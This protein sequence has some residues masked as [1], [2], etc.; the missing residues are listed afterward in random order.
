MKS[1]GRRRSRRR[2]YGG[3]DREVAKFYDIKD[4]RRS[5]TRPE[6]AAE[7]EARLK[8]EEEREKEMARQHI[9]RSRWHAGVRAGAA[10]SAP[11]IVRVEKEVTFLISVLTVT[12]QL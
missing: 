10:A 7:S 5:G 11:S 4:V 3:A 6:S 9:S 1:K 8:E 12:G 2:K